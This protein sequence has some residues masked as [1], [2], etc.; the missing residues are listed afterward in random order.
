MNT[1]TRLLVCLALAFW[2][3]TVHGNDQLASSL[4]NVTSEVHPTYCVFFDPDPSVFTKEFAFFFNVVGERALFHLIY[5]RSGGVHSTERTMGHAWSGDMVHWIVDTVAF[6]VDSTWWNRRHV[7]SPSLIEADGRTYM[8]YTGV[9]D[10]N[11]QRIGY[12]STAVLDTSNTVWDSPRVMV[13]DA[14]MTGW[15]V[16]D[17]P[18]YGGQTQFRDCYVTQ[19]PEHSGCLLM[20]YAAHD[21]TDAQLN[22]GGLVVGV[23]RSDS[24]SVDTW[25]DLGY[26]PSTLQS[27]TNISQLEGPII[28]SVNGTGT[29]WRLMFTSGGSPFGE[30]GQS[31]VR[32]E[33]LAPGASPADTTPANW[34]APVILQQYLNYE[35]A[36]FGW[37]GTEELH[38]PGADY[39]GG[40]MAW[41]PGHTDI[42]YARVNWNGSDFT[43]GAPIVT[44][45]DE[46]RSTVRGVNLSLAGWSP[47]APRVTFVIDSPFELTAK[48][49]VFDAQGRHTAT[50]FDGTLARGR[51]T[52]T[53]ELMTREGA[54][55]SSGVYFARLGFAGGSRTVQMAVAR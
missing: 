24:G 1:S 38:F 18:V 9:D 13:W 21:S 40:F 54:R 30:Y 28:F 45:V 47:S 42:A 15:A 48:L 35:P 14:S 3:G 36:S 6:A 49:E 33:S 46:V 16:P 22:R 20:Y 41:G 37:S 17:P 23:A 27:V 8:F 26:F 34:S 11:D 5:Q 19:D 53:W 7:W 44:S 32:F 55:V 25:H 50:P 10:Q 29:D 2:P 12:V 31:T 51:N 43:L 4:I 52:V 39:M